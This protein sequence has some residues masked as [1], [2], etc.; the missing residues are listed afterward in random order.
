MPKV[1]MKK[2]MNKVSDEMSF[3]KDG[4]EK[5]RSKP[6]AEPTATAMQVTSSICDRMGN[7]VPGVGLIGST[8]RI[9]A[10]LLNPAPTLADLRRSEQEI[11]ARLDGETGIIKTVL[12]RELEKLRE[13]MKRPYTEIR[14]DLDAVKDEIQACFSEMTPH[15]RNISEELADVKNIISHTYQLVRDIRYR[16]GIEK[17][18]GAYENFLRGANNLENTLSN[19]S[20]YIYELEVLA[21]QNL[22]PQRVKEYLRAIMVTEDSDIAQQSFKYILVVRAMYLQ[23]ST[24]FYIFQKDPERV[25]MEF[26]TFNN[27]FEEMCKV[28][29]AESGFEFDPESLP[30]EDLINRCRQATKV[31]P[32]ITR[33]KQSPTSSSFQESIDQFLEKIHL[34]ELQELFLEEGVTIEELATFNDVDLKNIGI[35]KYSHRRQILQSISGPKVNSKST[36][37]YSTPIFYTFTK[38]LNSCHK[39]NNCLLHID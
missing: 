30:P 26:E 39:S 16:D 6:W 3:I 18:E 4:I 36:Y 25:R 1:H 15:M 19:L 33:V 37:A 21:C 13:D 20:G 24:A 11:V 10:N 12:N 28:Y 8:L 35:K 38:I 7:F 27:D 5:V 9:G 14:E 32:D 2:A 29:K 34:S 23:L 17:I 31:M 22:N